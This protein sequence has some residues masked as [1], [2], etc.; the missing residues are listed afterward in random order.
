V[1][2]PKNPSSPLFQDSQPGCFEDADDDLDVET[3]TTV[4]TLVR[5]KGDEEVRQLI[6]IRRVWKYKAC[7]TKSAYVARKQRKKC[8]ELESAEASRHG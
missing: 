6:S 1:N 5:T 3:L 7:N 2:P 8:I 4:L